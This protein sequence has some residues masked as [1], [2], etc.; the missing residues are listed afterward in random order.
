M[1]TPQSSI[2]ACTRL[3]YLEK[4]ALTAKFILLTTMSMK[5]NII[6]KLHLK[7][8]KKQVKYNLW[9]KNGNMH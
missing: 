3:I 9:S 5:N 4:Y 8:A 1:L 6:Q 2:Y 7:C